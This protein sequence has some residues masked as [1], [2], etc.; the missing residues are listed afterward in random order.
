[1]FN[2]HV[3]EL[4]KF[5]K[6]EKGYCSSRRTCIEDTSGGA[7]GQM[8]RLNAH[9]TENRSTS[10]L[11]STASSI[12]WHADFTAAEFAVSCGDPGYQ[13]INIFSDILRIFNT[14]I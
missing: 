12:L 5:P 13:L 11:I 14:N 6:Y 4:V 3:T 9:N 2:V 7:D 1:M 10:V 8:L